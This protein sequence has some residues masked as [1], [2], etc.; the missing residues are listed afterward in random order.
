M[1][2]PCSKNVAPLLSTLFSSLGHDCDIYVSLFA[3]DA[4]YYHQ[5]DGYKTASQLPDNCKSYAALCPGNACRFLQNGDALKVV[6]GDSCQ[7]LVPYLWSEI[8][9]KEGNLE[10]HTGFEYIVARPNQKSR[11]HYSIESFAEIESTYSVAFDWAA[12]DQTP[13]VVA[14]SPLALLKTTASQGECDSPIAPTL[15][16]YFNDKSTAGSVYRQ[17]GDAVV[18]AAGGLCHVAVPYSAQVGDRLRTGQFVF[19][20]QPAPNSTYLYSDSDVVDFPRVAR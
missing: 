1:A 6:Q 17:Q 9:A 18:L 11:V 4:R 7:I 14:Q 15:T 16:K 13:A 2:D 20:L 19:T 3:S 10:P 8:P 12:P 5:H